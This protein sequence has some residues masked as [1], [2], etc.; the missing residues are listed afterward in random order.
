VDKDFDA[1]LVDVKVPNSPLD[2]YLDETME[3][4]VDKFLYNGDDRN[5]LKV[6]V[7]GKKILD[8][9]QVT[10]LPA[11]PNE[12]ENNASRYYKQVKVAE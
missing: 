10:V 12:Q 1:L 11:S 8:N 9:Q 3:S 7:A 5:I 6:Y 4:K 2:I